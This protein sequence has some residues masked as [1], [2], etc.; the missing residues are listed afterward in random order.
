MIEII[1]ERT[2]DVPVNRVWDLIERV[3]RLPQW[4]TGTETA[5][6][7]EGQGP[8]RKQRVTGRWGTHRFEIDQTVTHYEPRRVLAWRH[9]AERL[10]G[11]AAPK[12][13][14]QTE[15]DTASG[16]RSPH[17]SAADLTATP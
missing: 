2:L 10:D 6:P 12:I 14:R 8:G 4:F 16:T 5:V 3:E 13:S 15:L 9:D 17:S 7:L 1:R 11:R